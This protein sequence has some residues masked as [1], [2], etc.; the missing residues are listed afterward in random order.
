M[1]IIFSEQ[2]DRVIIRMKVVRGA[3]TDQSLWLFKI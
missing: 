2:I 3:K 1:L